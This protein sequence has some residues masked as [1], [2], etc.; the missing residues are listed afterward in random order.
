MPDMDEIRDLAFD[1]C[2]REEGGCKYTNDPADP[3]GP[4]KYGVALNYNRSVI[5]DKD[6]NGVIDARDVQALTEADARS[7]Y[8]EV[9]WNRNRCNQ[10]PGA[11]AFMYGDMVFNPGPGA[12]PKLLQQSLNALGA[13]LLVDGMLG[14]QTLA[15]AAVQCRA[16]AP[17]LLGE[18]CARRAQYYASRP[19]FG[20]YGLGWLRRSQRC[21]ASALRLC[22]DLA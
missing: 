3:G 5:P 10:L 1:F 8:R 21:L 4:T 6:G 22:W 13:N 9:Y 17:A 12:A 2:M 19:G 14:P 15:E 20:R 7:I 18:L 11:L 16:D